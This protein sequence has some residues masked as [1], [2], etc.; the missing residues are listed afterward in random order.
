MLFKGELVLIFGGL[1][2]GILLDLSESILA[3]VRF[4][5]LEHDMGF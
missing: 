1:N 2:S 3:M 4:Q 5:I